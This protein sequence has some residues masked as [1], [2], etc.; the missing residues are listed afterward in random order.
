MY[1]VGAASSVISL[2]KEANGDCAHCIVR[3]PVVLY[4][5]AVRHLITL[6]R[7]SSFAGSTGYL[8]V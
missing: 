1:R 7:R 3:R 8:N 5:D 2:V 6:Q 4:L